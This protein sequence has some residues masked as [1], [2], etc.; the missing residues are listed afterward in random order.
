MSDAWTRRRA[1]QLVAGGA[2]AVMA[3]CARGSSGDKEILRNWFHT[4]HQ[5][6][7][8]DADLDAVLD[9]MQHLPRSTDPSLQ[10]PLLFD[11]EVDAG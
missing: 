2:S 6:D 8:S 10:P 1:L 7:V 3:G 9:Y 4:R 5:L 11:P